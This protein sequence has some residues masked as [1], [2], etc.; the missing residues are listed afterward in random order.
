MYLL[1]P[2]QL[3]VLTATPE[4]LAR[5]PPAERLRLRFK[6]A[7]TRQAFWIALATAVPLLVAFF[8]GKRTG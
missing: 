5:L 6:H 3:S 7:Q 2:D 8:I 4:E 1:T